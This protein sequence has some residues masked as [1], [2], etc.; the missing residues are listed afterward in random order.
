[1]TPDAASGARANAA[2][3]QSPDD[4]GRLLFDVANVDFAARVRSR[5]DIERFNPH[6]GDM[7]LLDAIVWEAPDH[8]AAIAVHHVRRD[9]FWVPGHFPSKPIMP[10][11]LQ[12]EAGAQLACYLWLQRNPPSLVAFLRLEDTSFRSMVEPGDDLFIL[13]RDVKVGR[14]R[15]IADVQGLVGSRI[16][17]DARVSGMTIPDPARAAT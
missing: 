8:T 2:H 15:F 6:R 12:V 13:C 4:P 16:A 3:E 17:F 10:G 5:Q 11:V 14:R 9:A 1:M 7:G